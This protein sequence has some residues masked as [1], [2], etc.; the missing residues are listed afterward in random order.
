MFAKFYKTPTEGSTFT[1]DFLLA[2]DRTESYEYTERWTSPGDFTITLPLDSV[3][4]K[5]L[6]VFKINNI[7][8]IDGD[9]LWIQDIQYGSPGKITLSGQDCKGFLGLRRSTFGKSKIA[10]AEDYDVIKGTTAEC[11]KHYLDNNIISPTD[12]ERK[13]PMRWNE[14]TGITGLESDSYMAKLESLSDIVKTLCDNAGIGYRVKGDLIA[15]GFIFELAQG[16]DRSVEQYSNPRV[17]FTPSWKNVVSVEFEHS[18]SNLYNAIYATGAG[19]TEVVYRDNNNIPTGISRR[20]TSIDVS[21]DSVSDIEKYALN[22][23]QDNV[24]VH[25]YTIAAAADQYNNKYFLGD[26]VSVQDMYTGNYF[27]SVITEVTKSYAAG[28]KN[29][30]ITLGKQKPKLLQGIINNMINGTIQKR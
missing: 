23:V 5:N 29:I 28:Q 15:G 13:M 20:E 1:D 26:I 17:I 3:I 11:I 2:T 9:W 10:V 30:T 12:N 8:S 6:N 16:A 19:V 14:Y 4:R 21:V 27:S 18:V 7:I 22:A 24:E 25:S